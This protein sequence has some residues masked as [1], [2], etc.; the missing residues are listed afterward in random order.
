MWYLRH[1]LVLGSRPLA[2][3]GQ[4]VY[5]VAFIPIERAFLATWGL[6][7]KQEPSQN[8]PLRHPDSLPGHPST[9]R[10]RT[11]PTEDPVVGPATSRRAMTGTAGAPIDDHGTWA[12]STG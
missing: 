5:E 4:K 9:G 2:R 6:L 10:R 1:S 12:R 7:M 3:N 11:P 8:R